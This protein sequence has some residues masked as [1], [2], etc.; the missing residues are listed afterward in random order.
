MSDREREDRALEALIVWNLRPDKD[1]L[2]P[3][4]LPPLPEEVKA[5]LRSFR[6][7]FIKGLISEV[8]AADAEPIEADSVEQTGDLELVHG[9]N[10]AED[11]DEGTD[12]ELKQ[13]RKE[14]LDEL[15]R[16]KEEDARRDRDS[17]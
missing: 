11:I 3:E 12:E 8:D 9:M 17:S 1:C 4:M 16:E 13:R 5:S 10:R 14:V 7:G 2:D 15:R 6:P